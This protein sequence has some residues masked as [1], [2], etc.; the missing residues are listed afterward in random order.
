MGGSVTYAQEAEDAGGLC[1]PEAQLDI[2]GINYA[3]AIYDTLT[4]PNDKGEFVP[5]L[6]KSVDHNADYTV[7]TIGLRDG[8]KFHDGTALDSQVV[9]NNLDA[10]RG[11]YP[12][13]SPILFGLVFGPYIKSVDV[14]DPLT[15]NVTVAQPWPAFP[16]YL[17]SSSRLGI[18][19]QAQLDSKDC[20]KNLI[21]TGP[22]KLR[23]W[24]VNDHL[25]ADRNPNY[26]AKD[27]DGNQLP[28]LDSITFKPVPDGQQRLNG[29]QSG[30][31][32]LIHT[33]SDI[34]IEQL[35]AL[36]KQNK[37]TDNESDKFAE[38]AHLMLCTAPP[39]DSVCPGSP[40]ANVHARNAVALALDRQTLNHVRAKDIPQIASGPFAPGAVGYLSDAGFP[41]FNLDKAKQEVAAYKQD[42]GKDLTF[43]YGGTPDPEGVDTQNFIK[44]M[45]EAAGMKV[46]TYT[47]EQTQYINVAV[48][49]NFQMYGWRN[50]P[51]S[52]PDSL[53]VW[54]NCN[55]AAPAACD[56]LVNFGGFN[57]PVITSDLQ[58]GRT[59]TDPATRA[60][61]YEDLN[62]QFSKEL[63]NLWT[64]WVVW[65][66]STSTKVHD[67]FGPPLPDGSAPNPGLATGHSM[68]GLFKTS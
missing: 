15:V 17:W 49:R 61:Y 59:D 26:W 20:A 41:Q 43:T 56:N 36:A 45:F 13:R 67:I 4:M 38:V 1:L 21:G 63:Y 51:G 35:R 54:W 60:G 9:K 48:A 55:N 12:G 34:D 14:V 37:I 42:T 19:A 52:D 11:T 50:F 65:S 58:K 33:S 53:F 6:A 23:E 68:A 32:D 5:Y 25:T 2:S 3:R 44:S 28:Y 66:V 22:F 46:S 47:V 29:L 57:D 18:M 24:V 62:R 7:W 64:S 39:T 31:F 16:S 10:Y 27:K 8:I 40:F 30:Q